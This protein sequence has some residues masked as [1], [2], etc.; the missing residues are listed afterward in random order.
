VVLAAS[1]PSDWLSVEE[2]RDRRGLRLALTVSVPGPWGE[3]A[4][5]VFH[6]KKIPFARVRQ[7]AGQP[8]D[9]LFAWT[10]QRNAPLAVWD[11]EPAL[12]SWSE[13]LFLAERLA[14]DPPLIPSDPRE[15]A[16]MFGLAHEICG[17]EGFGWSRRLMLLHPLLVA[18]P[19]P[20]PQPLE[21]V[22]RLA[23]R[24]GYSRAAGAAAPARVAALLTMLSDVLRAQHARGRRFLV[25]DTLSAVDLHWAAFAAMV[26]PLPHDLCPMQEG[27]RRGY[28]LADATTRAAAD[29]ILLEHRDLIYR[30]YLELPVRL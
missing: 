29:P 23:A 5:V 1:A 28:V 30:E 2:A 21:I 15:R 25:G 18:A 6:V 17:Q 8:N 24:Y 3:A 13:I 12:G 9:A 19:D 7:E 10:G 27:L 26:E 16:S 11:D 20:I 22:A 4:K 14:P